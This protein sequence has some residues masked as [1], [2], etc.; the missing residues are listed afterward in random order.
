MMKNQC[1]YP[2]PDLPVVIRYSTLKR[3]N[4]SAVPNEAWMQGGELP[5]PNFNLAGSFKKCFIPKLQL[6]NDKV[7]YT[8]LFLILN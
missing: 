7:R 1:V 5:T 3:G 2:S 6:L 8:F 4:F